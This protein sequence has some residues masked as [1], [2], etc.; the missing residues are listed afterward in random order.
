[1]FIFAVRQAVIG[2]YVL[3]VLPKDIWAINIV[4]WPIYV[5]SQLQMAQNI[6]LPFPISDILYKKELEIEL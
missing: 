3:F 1:V 6:L 5:I 2:N 4:G